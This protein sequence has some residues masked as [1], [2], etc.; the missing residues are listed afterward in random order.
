MSTSPVSMVTSR[1]PALLDWTRTNPKRTDQL[2]AAMFSALMI[3]S[4]ALGY[5]T[6]S[7]EVRDRMTWWS[8][9]LAILS[10]A[11]TAFRRVVPEWQFLGTTTLYL[12]AGVGNVPDDAVGLVAIWIAL[13]SVSAYGGRHR[14]TA[15][16]AGSTILLGAFIWWV[17]VDGA[18][19]PDSVRGP[20][21]AYTIAVTT[22]LIASAW[23]FGDTMRIRRAQADALESRTKELEIARA[24]DAVQAVTEERLRIARELHDVLAHH[25]T[26]IGVQAAAAGR[27][28][29]RQP[30]KA[31]EALS[32]IETSSRET[33]G[34]LQR[35]LGFLRSDHPTS[36]SGAIA[37]PEPPQPALGS[38][39]QLIEEARATGQDVTVSV[40]GDLQTLPGS[41]SLSGYRI[42]QEALSN[43]RRHASDA[44]VM[45]EVLVRPAYVHLL[46]ENSRSP[47]FA[48][49]SA[50]SSGA[51][52]STGHGLMG[53]R[54][55]ARLVGGDL[56][57][58]PTPTGGW[59]V[60]A[61]LPTTAAPLP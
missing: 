34:E 36:P 23:L 1:W 39:M 7:V 59:R 32:S 28:L 14:N 54:E 29:D 50:A 38:V 22:G 20:A 3:A 13:Y 45:I 31:R 57:A 8:I 24:R 47:G 56:S 40:S 61:A 51:A 35:L 42:V 4:I 19:E 43:V 33:I 55:R 37:D 60:L 30:D 9:P 53:M 18:G 52:G 26:V 6:R 2:L 15:R 5:F 21:V 44:K 11:L 25:V 12:M 58:G 10:V 17:G 48:S 27:V 41:V 46:I 16:V 49:T